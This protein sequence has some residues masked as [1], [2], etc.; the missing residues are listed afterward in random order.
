M[1]PRA[2]L[3]TLFPY[4]TLFRSAAGRACQLLAFTYPR[5]RWYVR[6]LIVLENLWMRITGKEFRAFV[7]T[8]DRMGAVLESAGLVRDTRRETLVWT[9]DLYHR[10][11][12]V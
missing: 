12:A 8:P 10:G 3:S 1:I 9:F 2:P 4:T 7:H 6:T 5:D 11:I